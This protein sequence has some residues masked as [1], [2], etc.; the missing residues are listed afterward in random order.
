MSDDE[1][2]DDV[3]G[4]NDVL[5]EVQELDECFGIDAPAP[6]PECG[7][8]VACVYDFEGRPMIHVVDDEE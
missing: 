3:F 7:S 2:W 8:L 5:P 1:F 4:Q 6:C